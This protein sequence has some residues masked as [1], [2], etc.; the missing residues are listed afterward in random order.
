MFNFNI[1]FFSSQRSFPLL[2]L[3]TT[4]TLVYGLMFFCVQGLLVYSFFNLYKE[5]N[6]NQRSDTNKTKFVQYP[7]NYQP[8]CHITAKEAV[9]ALK[10][11]SSPG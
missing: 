3:L 11:V 6:I 8:P 7:D 4:K 10:R 5:S 1:G 2:P 9:S